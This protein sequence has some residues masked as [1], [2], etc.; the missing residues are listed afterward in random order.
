MVMVVEDEPEARGFMTEIL[1]L[2][3]YKVVGSSNGA[4][5]LDYLLKAEVPCLII[6]DLGMPVMSGPEF[7]AAL[8]ADPRLAKIPVVVVTA[9]D[10]SFARNLAAV[11]VFRKP[12]DIEALVQVVRQNC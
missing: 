3:G 8:L 7:R 10:P 12:V 9:M 2:E 6:L 4:E 11:R 5:A 1:Q